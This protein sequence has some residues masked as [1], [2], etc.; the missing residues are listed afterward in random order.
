MSPSLSYNNNIHNCILPRFYLQRSRFRE[1]MELEASLAG[2]GGSGAR[3]AI[4]E[5]YR[6]L[7]PGLVPARR[8][9][10]TSAHGMHCSRPVPLSV[11]LQVIQ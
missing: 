1:A 4:M 2:R 6:D 5:R 9:T 8:V 10:L 11:T 3:E 7:L